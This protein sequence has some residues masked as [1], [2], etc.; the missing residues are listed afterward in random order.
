MM[1]AFALSA[2]LLAACTH[3]PPAPPDPIPTPTLAVTLTPVASP[4]AGVSFRL[5]FGPDG[6]DASFLAATLAA[7]ETWNRALGREVFTWHEGRPIR[8]AQ[9]DRITRG[10]S[11]IIGGV[12]LREAGIVAFSSE[13][14]EAQRYMVAA[15]ELG[16]VLGLKHS[17]D[18][19]DLMAPSG[20]KDGTITPNDTRRALELLAEQEHPQ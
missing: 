5:Y 2:L 1:R 10:V 7:S 14:P 17:D 20:N 4:A 9:F 3:P 11:A 15:H 18:P 8:L 16:H 13:V 12:T 19:S 6:P